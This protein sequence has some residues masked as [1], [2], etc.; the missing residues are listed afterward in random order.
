MIGMAT[1][2]ATKRPYP[3]SSSF[4]FSLIFAA[5]SSLY[6]LDSISTPNWRVLPQN[7]METIFPSPLVT[8]NKDKADLTTLLL[9]DTIQYKLI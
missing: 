6:P 2:F 7:H 1:G 3:C 8:L 9:L 4:G 5:Q